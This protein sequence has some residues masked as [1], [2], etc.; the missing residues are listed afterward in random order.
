MITIMRLLIAPLIVSVAFAFHDA[1]SNWHQGSAAKPSAKVTGR[2][3]V[4][5]DL[6]GVGEKNLVANFNPNGS[7]LFHLMDSGPGNKA[8]ENSV[9]GAWSQGT[10]R[11]SFSGE[12][13]LPFGTCCREIGTLIF[14]G[15][16]DSAGQISGRVIFIGITTDE[17]N[18]NGFRSTVGTFTAQPIPRDRD[19]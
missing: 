7:V 4:K 11:I 10:T 12:V 16:F 18:F 5:F 2:W 19:G 14:K 17:E 3:R 13:E 15:Q 1:G 8:A 6:S 9:P